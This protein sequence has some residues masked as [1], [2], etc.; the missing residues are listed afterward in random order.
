MLNQIVFLLFTPLSIL[1]IP[2]LDEPA[3]QWYPTF[4]HLGDFL[5]NPNPSSAVD[6]LVRTLEYL[7]DK[8]SWPAKRIHLFGFAQ[9]GTV[10]AETGL[11]WWSLHR[12][13]SQ[14]S[15]SS[16]ATIVT[17]CGPL[18]SFPTPSSKCPTPVLVF[19]RQPSESSG[20]AATALASFR[21]G[22]EDVREVKV[23]GGEGMPRSR[24]EW[25]NVMRF[26]SGRLSHRGPSGSGL[27][28]VMKG[29]TGEKT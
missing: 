24:D 11:R 23:A 7:V 21:K 13:T 10:A 6:A 4:D 26:W 5:Q 16:L 2:Y 12:S 8:C 25:E 3:Y 15:S 1:R 29:A 17:I 28:E 14:S 22:Y 20:L 9:G 18:L 19:H 27:Y